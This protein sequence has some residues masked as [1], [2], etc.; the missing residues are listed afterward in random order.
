M[1]GA[2]PLD[3]AAVDLA[4]AE[5]EAAFADRTSP[6]DDA[7]LH[8]EC[9]DDGD[10][11]D[12]YGGPDWRSLGDETIVR[13]YAAA[14]FFS[15]AAFRYYIPAFM[16]WS[17]KNPD[18]VEYVVESTLRAFNPDDGGKS[19]RAFQISKYADLTPPQRQAVAAYLAAF[20]KHADLG[21]LARAALEYWRV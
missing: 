4:I 19:L 16:V 18:S 12:F 15:A 7:L 17:L 3:A 14:S 6:A 21:D 9:S 5:I 10:I 2:G 20:E 11:A 13:N 8:P 1:G